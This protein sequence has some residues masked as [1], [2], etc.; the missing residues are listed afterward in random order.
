MRHRRYARTTTSPVDIL[1]AVLLVSVTAASADVVYVNAA[2]GGGANNGTSWTNAYQGS[3]GLGVALLAATS[4]DEIWVA[5][6]TYKP[7]STNSRFVSF[8]LKNGVALYGGFDGSEVARAQRQYIANETI[9][10]GDLAGNDG[11]GVFSDNSYHVVT[12]AGI[13]LTAILDGFTITG[14]NANQGGNQQNQIGGG[15]RLTSGGSPTIANCLLTQNRCTFGGGAIYFTFSSPHISNTDFVDNIG[16]AFGGA[17]DMFNN[18]NPVL[19][20]CNF[21]GNIA[22]RAGGVELFQNCSPTM[23]RCTFIDNTATGTTGGGGLYIANGGNAQFNDCTMMDNT[24]RRG[25]GV[26]H[27]NSSPT[28]NNCAFTG[29]VT[30]TS[31][32][33]GGGVYNTGSSPDFASCLFAGNTSANGGGMRNLSNSNPDLFNCTIVDNTAT[34]LGGGL[35]NVGT[36]V[37]LT[38]CIVWGNSDINGSGVAA[39]INDQSGASTT[40][41]YC[42]IQGGWTGAGQNNFNVDPLF[43]DPLGGDYRLQPDSQCVNEGD[44]NLNPPADAADLDGHARVLCGRVDIGAYEFGLGDFD[45]DLDVD[46]FDF[47]DL[48]D[49][50]TGPGGLHDAGCDPADSDGDMD[51]DWIDAGAFQRAV[52]AP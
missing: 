32:G 26:H 52:T 46:P 5:L 19:T 8:A 18:C 28:F 43:A 23:T 34:S 13:N 35:A 38:S 21:I 40:A 29:N 45:C 42:D 14:G 51:V 16:G 1:T 47:G 22:S 12:G 11:S 27:Q 44:P 4:G 39:Q 9:L 36:S 2:S 41:S 48:L 37:D 17:F 33:Q 25:G 6:G 20:D 30:T 15:I 24:A 50:V 3:Q 31:G 10:S 49:C 7:T